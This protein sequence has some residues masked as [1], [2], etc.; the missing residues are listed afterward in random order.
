ME[1]CAA[2]P[3]NSLYEKILLNGAIPRRW[4]SYGI[5]HMHDEATDDVTL[6][7]GDQW[8]DLLEQDAMDEVAGDKWPLDAPTEQTVKY[9]GMMTVWDRTRTQKL[10][11]EAF[12][13]A[14]SAENGEWFTLETCASA[15]PL[16][17]AAEPGTVVEIAIGCGWTQR[18]QRG[19]RTR[20]ELYFVHGSLVTPEQLDAIGDT[21][22]GKIY[23]L[24]NQMLLNVHW[25]GR[26]A[27]TQISLRCNL[28]SCPF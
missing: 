12:S 11:S 14:V 2:T 25:G 19:K 7:I 3:P 17:T 4:N 1:A 13:L 10:Q 23:G 26:F 8:T 20:R 15:S 27:I 9:H 18:G 28:S 6:V 22:P 5:Q 21:S 24:S 16:T